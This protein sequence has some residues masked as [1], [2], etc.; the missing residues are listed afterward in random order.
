MRRL[1][2]AM[3]LLLASSS[4]PAFAQGLDIAG[5]DASSRKHRDFAGKPCL[6]TEGIARPL[7]SNPRILNHAVSLDNHCND[8]IKVRV[9][10]YRSDDCTD[11][12][13]PG[14]A[15]KEQVIGVFPAMQ[16]FRYEVKEQF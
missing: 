9:C 11:V 8:A 15:R 10:Y 4:S 5:S 16:L 14:H 3:A 1:D 6:Q 7:A 2:L 13:V 12:S